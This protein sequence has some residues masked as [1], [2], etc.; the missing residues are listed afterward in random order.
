MRY[1]AIDLGGKR[2]GIAVG[3][4]VTGLAS[5]VDVITTTSEHERL[6][7]LARLIDEHGPHALVLGLPLNMDGTPGPAAR[8]ALAF[9]DQLAQRFNLP[10]HTV[11][12]RL[13]SDTANQQMAGSGLTHKQKKARRDALAAAVILRDFL[14]G[15]KGAEGPRDQGAE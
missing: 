15:V 11:D 14:A 13:T 1:M 2:T 9:A 4:D 7:Q 10:V 5:P 8:H 6:N 12:E 3:D